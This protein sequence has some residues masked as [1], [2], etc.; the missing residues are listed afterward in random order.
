MHAAAAS[1]RQLP[2][3]RVGP[4]HLLLLRQRWLKPIQFPSFPLLE[5]M[6][7]SW[8]TNLIERGWERALIRTGG[9]GCEQASWPCS[10]S[11]G[12]T[13]TP[14]ASSPRLVGSRTRRPASSV[15]ALPSPALNGTPRMTPQIRMLAG[16]SSGPASCSVRLLTRG[17]LHLASDAPSAPG[18]PLGGRLV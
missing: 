13:S 3:P 10:C 6:K 14:P 16:P 11:C 18:L 2:R 4:R 12:C 5:H 17:R 1:L 7:G 8:R 9:V 15:R